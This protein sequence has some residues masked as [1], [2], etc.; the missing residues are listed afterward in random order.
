MCETKRKFTL[1]HCIW[2]LSMSNF[3]SPILDSSANIIFSCLDSAYSQSSDTVR[4]EVLIAVAD[5]FI[6]SRNIMKN[7][8]IKWVARLCSATVSL[9][10]GTRK[11]AL[12]AVLR[13]I[14]DASVN[15]SSVFVKETVQAVDFVNEGHRLVEENP[16]EVLLAW[17]AYVQIYGSSLRTS[18]N[19]DSLNSLLSLSQKLFFHA[20]TTEMLYHWRAMFNV[21]I[22]P[23]PKVSIKY[24]RVILKPLSKFYNKGEKVS[25]AC[26]FLLSHLLSCNS[27]TKLITSMDGEVWGHGI[28]QEFVDTVE[29]VMLS[30]EDQEIVGKLTNVVIDLKTPKTLLDGFVL[31]PI[32]EFMSKGSDVVKAGCCSL[33]HDLCCVRGRESLLERFSCTLQYERRNDLIKGLEALKQFFACSVCT[34]SSEQEKIT[35]S[36]A[37]ILMYNIGKFGD[38]ALG[39]HTLF[40]KRIIKDYVLRLLCSIAE[41]VFESRNGRYMAYILDA[42]GRCLSEVLGEDAEDIVNT[43][44]GLLVDTDNRPFIV[45][46]SSQECGLLCILLKRVALPR[47]QVVVLKQLLEDILKQICVV[48]QP[49]EL[50]AVIEGIGKHVSASLDKEDK[51]S[52]L[53][54]CLQLL[55]LVEIKSL[56]DSEWEDVLLDLV[57]PCIASGVTS[58]FDFS[59]IEDRI[60]SLLGCCTSWRRQMFGERAI[61]ALKSDYLKSSTVVDN[62]LRLLSLLCGILHDCD[63][64]DMTSIWML[65]F[66]VFLEFLKKGSSEQ[67]VEAESLWKSIPALFVC[68]KHIP[69]EN[70]LC[71]LLEAMLI[72]PKCS[73]PIL[74]VKEACDFFVRAFGPTPDN[75]NIL[76]KNPEVFE[77]WKRVLRS[78]SWEFYCRQVSTDLHDK[79]GYDIFAKLEMD[80]VRGRKRK[81]DAAN[82]GVEMKI[83][84]ER[85]FLISVKKNLEQQLSLINERLDQIQE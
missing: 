62:H 28:E 27:V 78:P 55:P 70:A 13:L 56:S 63:L 66:E 53:L 51:L 12:K 41:V 24:L 17:S 85:A 68:A 79:Y 40:G 58:S 14:S 83:V 32:Q 77:L 59:V 72:L 45:Y 47:K 16:Q 26:I 44:V 30:S 22:V 73:L 71:E 52:V 9:K 5:L 19:L 54:T 61:Q 60:L 15:L 48:L 18:G 11:K 39:S 29:K 20:E 33:L 1:I 74:D 49:S 80:S 46:M 25:L 82:V 38:L 84:N 69:P 75:D 42:L 57:I 2:I 67:K 31:V 10:S 65:L 6:K 50:L 35:T 36:V 7:F 43:L 4:A 21:F 8:A 76:S 81:I 64:K 37:L 3:P 23:P 34:E